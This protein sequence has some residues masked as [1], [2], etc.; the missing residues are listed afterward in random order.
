MA[1][2]TD[3]KRLLARLR[4]R[5]LQLL[6]MLRECR[7]LSATATRMSLSQSALSKMLQEVEGAFGFALFE[8]MA[9]GLALTARGAAV[10]Q[11]ATVL[12]NELA[13]GT[14]EIA[15]QRAATIV[16]L[17]APPF[18]AQAHLPGV[19]QKLFAQH[20]DC[21]VRVTEGGIPALFRMLMDG[22]VDALMT[23]LPAD[24]PA[25]DARRLR[26]ER[27]FDFELVVIAAADH[28]LV[29]ARRL[30][31]SRLREERWVLQGEASLARKV[32]DEMFRRAGALPPQE[33]IVSSNPSTNIELVAAGLGVALVPA[34]SLQLAVSASRVRRLKLDTPILPAS[35][36]LIHRTESSP[37][38]QM[39]RGALGLG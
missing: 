11:M 26:V 17:G 31:W 19:L 30:S 7:T 22:V 21:Q 25:S 24:V 4:F 27:L 36:A 10:V 9:R 28:A 8:R 37:R 3:L 2:D 34:M 32:L 14:G 33:T 6:V 16:R 5:H 29:R 20:G 23:G 18:V 38:V 35:V 13:H 39:L 15:Q 12:L 1:T